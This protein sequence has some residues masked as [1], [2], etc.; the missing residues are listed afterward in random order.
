MTH[1]NGYP[2]CRIDFVGDL[3]NYRSVGKAIAMEDFCYYTECPW[4]FETAEGEMACG[5]TIDDEGFT[6]CVN[7]ASCP[8]EEENDNE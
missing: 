6:L 1:G 5:L 8:R 7:V 2:V 4:C 3:C